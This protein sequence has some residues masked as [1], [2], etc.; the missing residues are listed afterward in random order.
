[1]VTSQLLRL[2]LIHS[3]RGRHVQHPIRQ[4]DAVRK[5]DSKFLP[6]ADVFLASGHIG[7][8]QVHNFL[9]ITH[10]CSQCNSVTSDPVT[11]CV[12]ML[13]HKPLFLQRPDNAV[14]EGKH[15]VLTGPHLNF[16]VFPLHPSLSLSPC[17]HS[18]PPLLV[19]N[20]LLYNSQILF[21]FFSHCPPISK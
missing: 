1:M 15:S 3:L 18:P 21:L 7:H 19:G 14:P 6:N 9:K 20:S 2:S 12:S 16:L 13:P 8:H 5:C 17:L 4:S 10:T 11:L